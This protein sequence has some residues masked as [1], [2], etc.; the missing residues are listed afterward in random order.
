MKL[1]FMISIY[2]EEAKALRESLPGVHIVRT[3]KGKSNRG[4]YYCEET[5][6]VIKFLNT[7]RNGAVVKG[8]GV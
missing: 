3:V 4:R 5:K 6:Q 8:R 7:L 1:V 2:K